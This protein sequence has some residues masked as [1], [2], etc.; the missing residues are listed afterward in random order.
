MDAS[1]LVCPI[2]KHVQAVLKRHCRHAIHSETWFT[3]LVLNILGA[4]WNILRFNF[5]LSI[6]C[7]S[8]KVGDLRYVNSWF[9]D[10]LCRFL[11]LVTH[12]IQLLLLELQKFEF[13]SCWHHTNDIKSHLLNLIR[14]TKLYY[15]YEVLSS[16]TEHHQFGY[17]ITCWGVIFVAMLWHGSQKQTENA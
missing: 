13:D 2:L 5:A 17:N 10:I 1:E 3:N 7:F 11:S 15:A 8:Q 6:S 16:H 9:F 4:S 12:S 14:R